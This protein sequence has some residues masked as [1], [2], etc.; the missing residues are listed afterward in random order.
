MRNGSKSVA[1]VVVENRAVGPAQLVLGAVGVIDTVRRVLP[2]QI[3]PL[4]TEQRLIARRIGR[5]TT[6]Y[7]MGSE[8]PHVTES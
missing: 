8:H 3:D 1:Q 4:V 2:E 6:Q 7:A 5:V